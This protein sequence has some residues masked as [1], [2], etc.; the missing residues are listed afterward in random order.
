MLRGGRCQGRELVVA[1]YMQINYAAAPMVADFDGLTVYPPAV[2]GHRLAAGITYAKA[3]RFT[4]ACRC[5]WLS[6]PG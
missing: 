6:S 4:H 3:P 2:V 5:C 1:A